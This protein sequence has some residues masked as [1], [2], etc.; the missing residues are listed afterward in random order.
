MRKLIFILILH[1]SISS[2]AQG[3]RELYQEGLK[4]Y[5][6]KNYELFK[7]KMY[8]IDSM[9]PNYPAVV[10]N[11]AGSYALTG[12][13]DKS[14][15]ILNKY[16]LMDASQDFSKDSDFDALRDNEGFKS[17]VAKQEKLTA[18]IPIDQALEWTVLASHPESI[19]YSKKEKAF[20]IGGVRDGGIWKIEEGKSPL[21]WAPS[22]KDSW[23]VM[24]L[25]ISQDNK[26]LWACTAAM[27]NFEGYT[28][29]NQGFSSVLKYDLKSGKCISKYPLAGGHIFGDLVMDS[30]GNVY[31][32]DG[33]ANILYTVNEKS[34]EL[35][36][37]ID[38][39]SS[40]FNL[41]GLTL[42]DDET[43][44][45]ISDYIDGIYKIDLVTKKVT[46]LKIESDEVLLK[47]IDGLYFINNSLIGL[48]N[49]NTPNRVVKYPLNNTSDA[50][51]GKEVISQAGVL[52]EPTQGVFVNGTFLYITN[53]PWA[54]YDKD[55]NF[56]P[57]TDK[58]VIGKYE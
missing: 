50:I 48:H 42:N 13:L 5:E 49:G 27:E 6:E 32:S 22:E 20:Y 51:I 55:G 44:L 35:E 37:F 28:P 11:L 45:Y 14:V 46:K 21:L 30:K 19:T 36:I 54:A 15:E 7:E 1:T 56:N 39:S 53:S 18:N 52:G 8:S 10:Y 3:I 34:K 12:E 9:R 58:L 57:T 38:L 4:A 29:E 2:Q 31:V 23:S 16:I 33:T 25:E 40:V 47:G 43:A 26:F 17:I 24:G 41:Q